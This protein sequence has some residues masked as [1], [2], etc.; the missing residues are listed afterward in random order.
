[1][2]KSSPLLSVTL[3]ENKELEATF[4]FYRTSQN[5]HLEKYIKSS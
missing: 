2:N 1:M 3:D 4:V 5:G